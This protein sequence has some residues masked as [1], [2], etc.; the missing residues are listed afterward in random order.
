M[1]GQWTEQDPGAGSTGS[2]KSLAAMLGKAAGQLDSGQTDIQQS[3]GIFP[4]SWSGLAA[5][6]A[7][8]RIEELK[9]QAGALG[10]AAESVKK[11]LKGYAEELDAIKPLA[12]DQ[13]F[14]RDAAE[15]R[16]KDLRAALVVLADPVKR[17]ETEAELKAATAAKESAA[18][19]LSRLAKRRQMAD[20]VALASVRSAIAEHW[21]IPPGDWPNERS[22]GQQAGYEYEI[23]N[24]LGVTTDQYTAKELMD[25]FKAH[26][27]EI[28]PFP[29]KGSSKRFE[30]GAVFEL[31]ETL[32]G[33]DWEVE[34]GNV[35]VTTT[36]TSVKFT[37]VSDG[38][39]DGPGSTIEFSVV[40]DNGMFYLKQVADARQAQAAMIPVVYP[41]A[42]FT[43]EDQAYNFRKVI[44]E[45]ARK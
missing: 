11:A 38:Y 16:E 43:W 20:D 18:A 26:P 33:V 36:D 25:L 24:K 35:V 44:L 37:V 7:K 31:S 42:N 23:R 13:I 32:R 21:D 6:A 15:K 29:V 17:R 10:S 1:G 19:S 45:R 28:F 3:L 12:N 5:N 14:L 39:F 2:M 27:E 41:G 34:T 8:T 40:E 9:M 22:W 4:G 30:D